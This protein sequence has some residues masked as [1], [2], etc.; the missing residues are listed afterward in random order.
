MREDFAEFKITIKDKG[1]ELK[2][3]SLGVEFKDSDHRKTA[4]MLLGISAQGA[5][6][7]LARNDKTEMKVLE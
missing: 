1:E 3:Y 7:V 2:E 5:F 4:L 6:D